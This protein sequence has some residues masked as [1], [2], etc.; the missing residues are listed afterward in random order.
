[1]LAG[2][3]QLH[4]LHS[5]LRLEHPAGEASQLHKCIVSAATGP[6]LCSGSS[7]PQTLNP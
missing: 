6:H 3:G 7:Q 1:M 5:R 4:D 2:E